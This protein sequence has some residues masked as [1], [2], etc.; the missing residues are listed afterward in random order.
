MLLSTTLNYFPVV[1]QKSSLRVL[2]L[3]STSLNSLCG[4]VALP[5]KAQPVLAWPLAFV[6]FAF[7]FC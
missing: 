3:T 7:E 6:T 2:S 5:I 4:P 1:L